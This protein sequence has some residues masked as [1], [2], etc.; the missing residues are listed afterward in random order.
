MC[1]R[2][3]RVEADGER[4][5]QR[6]ER[7]I[8]RSRADATVSR[9]CDPHVLGEPAGAAA[10]PDEVGLLAV[11]GFAGEAREAPA[12]ADDR[13]RGHVAAH[14]P[15]RDRCRRR[16]PTISPQNSWPITRPAGIDGRIFRSEP[17]MPQAVTSSTSSP[18][19]GVGIGDVR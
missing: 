5:D 15:R 1:A 6:A 10:H 11:R 13:E 18:G 9:W 4:L 7:G 17:Q 8:E 12:A 19:P 16:S 2:S 14:P 3:H